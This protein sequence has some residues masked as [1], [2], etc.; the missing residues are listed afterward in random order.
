MLE[1]YHNGAST[2]SQ[3]VRMILAEKGLDYTS[4]TLD[5]ISGEQHAPAYVKLNPNHVVPTL[6]DDGTVFIEST[7]INEYLDDA[8]PEPPMRP[9]DPAGRHALRLW[10]RRFDASIQ[11]SI[12]VVTFA[13]GPRRLLL[14]QPAE[15]REA[16]IEA[17]PDPENRAR[18]RSVVEHGIKAPEFA[19]SLARLVA[20]LDD[21]EVALSAQPWL[22]G[23]GFG[24]ADAGVLPYV[25]RLDHLAMTPLLSADARPRLADWYARIQARPAFAVAV[26]EWL[27]APILAIFRAGGEAVWADVE[28]MTRAAD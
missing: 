12:S 21:M 17:I 25:L 26:T 5:L 3:K 19:G 2:C 24:L 11:A 18:R 22:S 10:S 6:V 1:L 4:H 9:A 28:P 8:F 14:E 13:I 7:L 15:I 20:L 27:P 16:N 23:E